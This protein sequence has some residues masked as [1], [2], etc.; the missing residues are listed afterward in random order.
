MLKN[1]VRTFMLLGTAAAGI[2]TG[3]VWSSDEQLA[4]APSLDT[5]LTDNIKIDPNEN[6]EE[7]QESI[8]SNVPRDRN[9]EDGSATPQSGTSAASP[10]STDG[11]SYEDIESI[12]SGEQVSASGSHSDTDINVV[13]SSTINVVNNTAATDDTVPAETAGTG[14]PAEENGTSA[15]EVK[16]S[17]DSAEGDTAEALGKKA[18]SDE[19]AAIQDSRNQKKENTAS[20]NSAGEKNSETV[21]SSVDSSTAESTA[22]DTT[23]TDVSGQNT[24]V[25]K[26]GS[27]N[28]SGSDSM[29]AGAETPAVQAGD[30]GSQNSQKKDSTGSDTHGKREP[31]YEALK[32]RQ[33][34]ENHNPNLYSREY[35]REMYLP[36][37]KN[38]YE[39]P[40][41][42]D[43]YITLRDVRLDKKGPVLVYDIG[44]ADAMGPMDFDGTPDDNRTLNL[45][46]RIG[47]NEGILHRIDKMVL[48]FYHDDRDFSEV[49]LDYLKCTGKEPILVEK[50]VLSRESIRLD[51]EFTFAYESEKEK[52]LS[53]EYLTKRFAPYALK[54][55]GENFD[56]AEGS[57]R[58][59]AD[60]KGNL[61]VEMT[62]P[63]GEENIVKTANYV[64][65]RIER[66][67]D[68]ET[69]RK[70]VLPRINSMKYV[71]VDAKNGQELKE[72]V[73][74]DKAC[75][76]VRSR[77]KR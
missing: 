16:N 46:C 52:N 37:F 32:L 50:N 55:I 68:I 22:K 48:V 3:D 67:C 2:S 8:L 62:V 9:S 44:V 28:Q 39:L 6:Y 15:A 41:E 70:W 64:A 10:E 66:T 40:Q 13:N 14:T 61:I 4:E 58:M 49:S 12:A 5:E 31:V 53:S 45:F 35:L 54:R 34:N 42:L 19:V 60:E 57:P 71:Y 17:G 23:G 76:A 33:H 30:T 65:G 59:T 11:S 47:L 1:F 24:E 36:F 27:D 43:P 77:R 18:D 21:A 26:K 29:S 74:T 75:Q 20:D 7:R 56:K 63:A 69:Y 73:V 51:D 38:T 25:K 72:V